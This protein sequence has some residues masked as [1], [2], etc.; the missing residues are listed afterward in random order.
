MYS[1]EGESDLHCYN[2]RSRRKNL[3]ETLTKFSVFVASISMELSIVLSTCIILMLYLSYISTSRYIRSC[4]ILKEMHLIPGNTHFSTSIRTSYFWDLFN[5]F[6]YINLN[7]IFLKIRYTYRTKHFGFMFNNLCMYNYFSRYTNL[8]KCR[9]VNVSW[10]FKNPST[11]AESLKDRTLDLRVSYS[12]HNADFP[13][14][15]LFCHDSGQLDVPIIYCNV[16]TLIR[17]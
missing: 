9:I 4:F 15:M 16:A 6:L 2:I 1:H 7:T 17:G 10:L 14:F 8:I 12:A 5:Y 3:Y 13:V 11:F